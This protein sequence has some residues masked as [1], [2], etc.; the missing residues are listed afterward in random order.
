MKVPVF[1]AALVGAVA[2]NAQAA[3]YPSDMPSC[4]VTCG[5]N[6]FAKATSGDIGCQSSTDYNC[7]CNKPNFLYGVRDC[8]YQYCQN[9]TAASIAIAWVNSFCSKY[10]G[11]ITVGSE[12]GTY[13]GNGTAAAASTP[14]ATTAT[15]ETI[16]SGST[17]YVTTVSSTLYGPVVTTITTPIVSTVTSG[18]TGYT[19][20][21][22]TSTITTEN[23][24]GTSYTATSS[25]STSSTTS[26]SAGAAPHMTAGPVVGLLAAGLAAALL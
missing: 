5:N 2:V 17:T 20:T 26:S 13:S 8:S 7:L 25:S 9:N 1:V 15:P 12:T 3:A 24:S 6:M 22:G 10:S 23:F 11:T 21:L 16:T 14:T 19:T 18:G 4:G